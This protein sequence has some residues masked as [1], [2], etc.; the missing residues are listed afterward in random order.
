MQDCLA[1]ATAAPSVAWLCACI[2]TPCPDLP[3][4]Q[5][6]AAHPFEYH[7]TYLVNYARHQNMRHADM[8][9]C[10]HAYFQRTISGR[11]QSEKKISHLSPV[12]FSH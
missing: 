10:R 11:L 4:P 8:P 9:T 3:G 12:S 2:V 7:N 5:T 6:T 1:A